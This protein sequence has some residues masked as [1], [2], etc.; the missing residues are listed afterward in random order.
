MK[1]YSISNRISKQAREELKRI[2]STHERYSKSYFFNPASSAGSRRSNERKFKLK[3]PDV[4]FVKN[5]S[6]IKVSV[7]YIESCNN[8]YYQLTVTVDA[9]YK[10][11]SASDPVVKDIRVIKNLLK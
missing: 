9:F 10:E 2:V 4:A 11:E 6:L 1:I 3:N 8:V 7:S 5:G